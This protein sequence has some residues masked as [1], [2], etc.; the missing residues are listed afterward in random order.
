MGQG[1]QGFFT[2]MKL[3]LR[4]PLWCVGDVI[5][6][7]GTGRARCYFCMEKRHGYLDLSRWRTYVKLFCLPRLRASTPMIQ[8][9]YRHVSSVHR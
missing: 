4:Y 9:L 2:S 3:V 5:A 1:N 8:S 7:T 6:T